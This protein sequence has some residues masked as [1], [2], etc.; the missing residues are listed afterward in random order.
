MHGDI[1]VSSASG[2]E[3]RNRCFA[4]SS[5]GHEVITDGIGLKLGLAVV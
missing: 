4:G 2:V 5:G 3:A 1:W